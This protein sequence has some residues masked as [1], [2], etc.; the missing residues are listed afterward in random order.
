MIERY[1]NEKGELAV[2]ISPGYG[3]GF[4]TW[5]GE[6]LAYDR[7]IIE[8]WLKESTSIEDLKRFVW[9]LG[10]DDVYIDRYDDLEIIYIPT[11]TMFCIT[12]YDGCESIETPKTL[13]MQIA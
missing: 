6:D 12:E 5:Y 13:R 7:R 2:L 1:Y 3:G 10:Y 4:S 8:Y 11:G 9:E